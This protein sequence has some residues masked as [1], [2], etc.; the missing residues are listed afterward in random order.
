MDFSRD[1][2]QLAVG[3]QGLQVFDLKTGQDTRTLRGHTGRAIDASFSK[4]GE[5]AATVSIDGTVIVWNVTRGEI[6]RKF[7]FV[8]RLHAI[9]LSPDGQQ[10]TIGMN[11]EEVATYSVETG[12]RLWLAKDH[13]SLGNMAYSP[14]GQW[15][16]VAGANFTLHV[17]HPQTGRSHA[18]LVGHFGPERTESWRFAWSPDS[19]SIAMPH[20]RVKPPEAPKAG[21]S[22]MDFPPEWPTQSRYDPKAGP[23]S[24]DDG[25]L[26]LAIWNVAGR[27]RTRVFDEATFEQNLGFQIA[28]SPD[29]KTIAFGEITTRLIDPES[30]KIT[31]TLPT[32]PSR[33]LAFLKDRLLLGSEEWNPATQKLRE[34]LPQTVPFQVISAAEG[35]RVLSLCHDDSHAVIWNW[36]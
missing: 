35:R 29:G 31:K 21:D 17:Y 33:G 22:P 6:I 11:H 25:V 1:G 13:G 8:A 5:R 23:N 27:K 3:A 7:A 4:D 10:F 30:G 19:K 28:W 20:C 15:L 34:I 32:N 16:A 2:D 26:R 12:Q 36:K 18:K 14:D 9:A 24:K